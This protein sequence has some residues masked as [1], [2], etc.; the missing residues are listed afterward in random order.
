MIAYREYAFM[1]TNG[2]RLAYN[3]KESKRGRT[4]S[5]FGALS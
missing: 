3:T 1:F 2:A 5:V 4:G